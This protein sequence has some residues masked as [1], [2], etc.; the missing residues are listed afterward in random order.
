MYPL[1]LTADTLA[2]RSIREGKV[3]HSPDILSDP[4]EPVRRL[5]QVG[6][7]RSGIVVPMLRSGSAVGAISVARSDPGGRPATL[8]REGDRAAPDVRRS[9]RDRGGERAPV[10]R[11]RGAD[12]ASWRARW[13]SSRRSVR[14]GG[15][16]ARPWTCPPCSRRSSRAPSSS[17]A[18]AAAASTSTTRPPRSSISRRAIGPRRSWSRCCGR[19]PS[20]LGKARPA[21]P[22][23]RR[24]PVEV[25]DTLEDQ[26]YQVTPLLRSTLNQ[27]GISL[28]SRQSRSCWSRGSWAR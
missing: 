26:Q 11:A 22:A 2:V 17:R 14:W 12:A 8:H 6:R 1:P 7:Y 15:R 3:V 24:V 4:S 19:G 9:G 13:R 16:S 5:A 27:L 28:D 18:R 21:E 20:A 23:L 25:A 10:P